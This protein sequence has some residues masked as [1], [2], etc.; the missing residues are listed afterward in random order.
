MELWKVLL[1]VVY[2]CVV[3]LTLS[4][5]ACCM[6][7]S[8]LSRKEEKLMKNICD[9]EGEELDSVGWHEEI[10]VISAPRDPEPVPCEG[11]KP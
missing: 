6:L 11:R 3:L 9:M 4:A 5:L 2:G 10:Q 7:S 8:R 1:F